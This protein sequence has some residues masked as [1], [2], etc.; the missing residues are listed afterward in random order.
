MESRNVHVNCLKIQFGSNTKMPTDKEIFAFFRKREWA[1]ESL[2]AM[3]R[4]PREYSV[5]VKFQ[6]EDLMKSALLQC[7]PSDTFNYDNGETAQVTF[8]T[9]RGD[10]R[11][12]RLFGLPIEVD[13]KHVAAVLSKYGKIHQMVRERFGPNTGYPILNGVRGAHMEIAT[14]IPPQLHVQHIQVRVFYEGMQSKCF[15]C[16][17]PEHVKANCPK[18]VSVSNRLRQN[19][20]GLTSYAD[21]LL[22]MPVSQKPSTS[23]VQDRL[24]VKE[25]DSHGEASTAD[26]FVTP[27]KEVAATA[28]SAAGS[29]SQQEL[30]AESTSSSTMEAPIATGVVLAPQTTLGPVKSIESDMEIINDDQGKITTKKRGRP[31]RKD[32]AR[33]PNGSD[34]PEPEAAKFR[35]LEKQSQR[36]RGRTKSK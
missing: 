35:L 15:V 28:I 30:T 20:T 9:A 27:S 6:S 1:P 29:T 32:G 18:R 21:A 36:T 33:K 4:E 5:Y 7:P 10:F 31:S 26:A 17:S 16:G 2:L 12:V 3:F 24:T 19:E 34:S 11:Y 14:V 8:A 22:G 25:S 13:E 23:G